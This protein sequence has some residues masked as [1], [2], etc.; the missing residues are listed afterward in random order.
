MAYLPPR[1]LHVK[2]AWR[3]RTLFSAAA[4]LLLCLGLGLGL[5]WFGA[6]RARQWLAERATWSAGQ[7]V[8]GASVTGGEQVRT[9]LGLVPLIYSYELEVSFQDAG[10]VEHVVRHEVES[11]FQRA[12]TDGEPEVR[13]DAARPGAVALSWTM[14]LTA[15]RLGMMAFFLALAPVMVAGG[16]Q[17]GRGR[18]TALRSA[19]ACA[20]RSDEL[21]VAIQKLEEVRGGYGTSTGKW[22]L[23]YTLEPG[24]GRRGGTR[25]VV[26]D[27]P[28]IVVG[29]GAAA[30]AV[31][32]ISRDAPEHPTFPRLDL[33]PFEATPEQIASLESRLRAAAA[34]PGGPERLTT[35][36]S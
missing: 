1:P 28:P 8:E 6:Q 15:G 26:L 34:R 20:E 27:G 29:E 5:G 23:R 21:L 25:E 2:A 12:P 35:A 7:V 13:F 31:G 36:G 30:R 22:R 10:G 17:F 3:G 4:V 24:T 14:G 32:L 11:L 19:R 9:L 33:H 18:W 16:L